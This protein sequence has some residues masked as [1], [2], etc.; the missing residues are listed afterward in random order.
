MILN[1]ATV[2]EIK[3]RMARYPSQRSAILP[4]LTAAYKQIGHLNPDIYREIARILK[5]PYVEVAEAASFYT[6]FP[7]H[8]V[9][10]H[11]IQVCQNISCSLRGADN[12]I[13]YLEKKLGIKM[14]ETTPDKMFTL[15]TVECL[16]GCSAAPMMQVNETYY[17]DLTRE[18]IDKIL[19]ELRTGVE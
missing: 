3:K 14:G 16:G 17:E 18:R 11:L 12:M 5:V 9:G 4:G 1:E 2:N 19:D 6:M 15:I 7:K 8:E 13:L 10:R